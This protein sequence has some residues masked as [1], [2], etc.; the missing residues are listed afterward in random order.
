MTTR[1]VRPGRGRSSVPDREDGTRAGGVHAA[2]EQLVDVLFGVNAEDSYRA[3]GGGCARVR[4]PRWVPAS[5][6]RARRGRAA[7][8]LTVPPQAFSLSASGRVVAASFRPAARM[9]RAA[10]T[11]RSATRPQWAQPKV[12]TDNSSFGPYQPPPEKGRGVGS[13]RPTPAGTPT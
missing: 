4:S 3:C 8:G 10:L 6:G 5:L 2:R 1:P 11:S 9:F 12:R 13:N 7:S